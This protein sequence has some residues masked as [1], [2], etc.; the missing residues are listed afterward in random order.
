[1]SEELRQ[2]V[3][4]TDEILGLVDKIKTNKLPGTDGIHLIILKESR[5]EIYPGLPAIAQ[6]WKVAYVS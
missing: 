5:C 6:D 1:M 4:R 3:V 2:I